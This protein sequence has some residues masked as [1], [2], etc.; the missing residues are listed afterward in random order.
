MM[1]LV[2]CSHAHQQIPETD[3]PL[4]FCQWSGLTLKTNRTQ[5]QNENRSKSPLILRDSPKRWTFIKQKN[6]LWPNRKRKQ[7]KYLP[8]KDEEWHSKDFRRQSIQ[9]PP[10]TVW[11]G[12]DSVRYNFPS[13][14]EMNKWPTRF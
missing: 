13:G 8:H 9:K 11:K 5:P 2:H 3:T 12:V 4:P 7:M 6:I 10:E 14:I 1:H